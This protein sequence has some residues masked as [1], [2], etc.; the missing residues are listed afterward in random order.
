MSNHDNYFRRI[1]KRRTI[2]QRPY[3]WTVGMIMLVLW[4]I[5]YLKNVAL[6]G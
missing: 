6:A 2:K 5:Q 4:L 1:I 3:W